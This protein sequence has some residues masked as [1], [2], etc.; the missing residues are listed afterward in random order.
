MPSSAATKATWYVTS[1]ISVVPV[2]S[3]AR[4]VEP[5]AS[6]AGGNRI[7]KLLICVLEAVRHDQRLDGWPQAE[8]AL[9]KASLGQKEML[10]SLEDKK[11]RIQPPR[12]R[13]PDC[14]SWPN[15][16]RTTFPTLG[17]LGRSAVSFAV[18]VLALLAPCSK[19][20]RQLKFAF[21]GITLD[22]AQI[23]F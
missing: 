7:P 18:L 4:D 11:P 20:P 12:S 13:R 1:D 22:D 19:R 5:A 16:A 17:S 2:L 10:M 8:M 23:V 9:C 6:V 21:N 15:Y 3:I 14:R